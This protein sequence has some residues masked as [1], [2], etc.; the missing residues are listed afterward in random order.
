MILFVWTN[1]CTI[2]VASVCSSVCLYVIS[3]CALWNI[4]LF[5]VSLEHRGCGSRLLGQKSGFYVDSS[6]YKKKKYA[7]SSSVL[8]MTG[9]EGGPSPIWVPASIQTLYSEYFLNSSMTYSRVESGSLV[10]SISAASES[11]LESGTTKILWI[12]LVSDSE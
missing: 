10:M 5:I 2:C 11:G 7:P 3:V 4:P 6:P 8:T 12:R 1:L 9:G